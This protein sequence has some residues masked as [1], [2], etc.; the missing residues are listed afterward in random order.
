MQRTTPLAVS[1]KFQPAM[2]FLIK[3]D[4]V[5]VVTVGPSRPEPTRQRR[6]LLRCGH[7]RSI[8]RGATRIEVM[9]KG[10]A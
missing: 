1:N 5:M 6:V 7:G 8:L 3:I 10:A 4:G 9:K 2:T